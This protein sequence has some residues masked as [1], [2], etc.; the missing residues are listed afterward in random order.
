[1]YTH[2]M[3]AATLNIRL[4]KPTLDPRPSLRTK[5]ILVNCVLRTSTFSAALSLE[6]ILYFVCVLDYII[7]CYLLLCI[8]YFI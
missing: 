6:L 7:W 4:E 8:L 2:N 5:K 1:V 3:A